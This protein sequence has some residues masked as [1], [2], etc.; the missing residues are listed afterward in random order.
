MGRAD[1]KGA[2]HRLK[3]RFW[4]QYLEPRYD[5]HVVLDDRDTAVAMWR[6]TG[7]PCFQVA[8]GNY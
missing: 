5:V 6:R 8:K 4:A 3:H 1:D 7:L 2:E